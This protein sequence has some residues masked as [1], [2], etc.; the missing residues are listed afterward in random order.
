ME[1]KYRSKEIKLKQIKEE[2]IEKMAS[3]I[4]NCIC[5]SELERTKK[6][7]WFFYKDV[8][9]MFIYDKE[10]QEYLVSYVSGFGMKN[11]LGT[12]NSF[13]GKTEG[14]ITFD[15][16]LDNIETGKEFRIYFEKKGYILTYPCTT[17]YYPEYDKIR[18]NSW[19]ANSK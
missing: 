15:E 11:L 8:E 7:I 16:F 14:F 18:R 6:S 3:V 10:K 17:I 1:Y 2:E 13:I 9:I 19:N 5:E 4:K 12:L